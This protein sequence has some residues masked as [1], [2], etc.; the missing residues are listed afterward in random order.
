M[1]IVPS[2]SGDE[3][4]FI[5]VGVNE[6]QQVVSQKIETNH[7][8]IQGLTIKPRTKKGRADLD[9]EVSDTHSPLMLNSI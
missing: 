3:R 9:G 7:E 5:E 2:L 4:K 1:S 8:N 6:V